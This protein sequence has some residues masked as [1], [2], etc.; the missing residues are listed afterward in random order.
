[1]RIL[2]VCSQGQNRSR[3]LA[4]YLKGK[5]FDTDY[6]GVDPEGYNPLTQEQVDQSDIIIAVRAH[7]KDSLIERFDI[8]GKKVIALEVLD[9]P[10]RFST[11]A[12]EIA[13]KS[14]HEFQEKYVYSELRRQ[15]GNKMHLLDKNGGPEGI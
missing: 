12:Q 13:K 6:G 7:I 11:E 9:N 2:I 4:G 14:W 15:I 5:G 8:K 1:M 3:Y 10:K